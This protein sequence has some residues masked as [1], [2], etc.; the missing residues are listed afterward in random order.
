LK[1]AEPEKKKMATAETSKTAQEKRG[2]KIAHAV[3][4]LNERV[5]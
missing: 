4:T 1:G 2:G 5:L 3:N